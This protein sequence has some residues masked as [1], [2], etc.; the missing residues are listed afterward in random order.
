MMNYMSFFTYDMRKLKLDAKLH[1]VPEGEAV[2]IFCLIEGLTRPVM[3]FVDSGA[4][5][6]LA[7]D[8]VPEKEFISVKLRDGPIP[9]S[10]ASGITAY[11]KAEYVTISR[12]NLPVCSRSNPG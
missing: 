9:L 3:C 12:W 8:G 2:F 7:R 6:W 5:C 1:K 4:N 10:V 11:A